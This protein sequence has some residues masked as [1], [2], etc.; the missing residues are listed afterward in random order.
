M[1]FVASEEIVSCRLLIAVSA[2]ST[3]LLGVTTRK[4][5]NPVVVAELISTMASDVA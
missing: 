1:L 4:A 5:A 2:N 3:R